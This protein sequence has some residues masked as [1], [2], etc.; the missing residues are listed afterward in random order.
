MLGPGNLTCEDLGFPFELKIDPLSNG[1]YYIP[2]NSGSVTI[3]ITSDG[4]FD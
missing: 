2:D 1:T 4:I 3:N